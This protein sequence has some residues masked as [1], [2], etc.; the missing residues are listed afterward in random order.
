MSSCSCG[1]VVLEES[2]SI[3]AAYVVVAVA[4]EIG[5]SFYGIVAV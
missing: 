2:F 1:L 4:F 3:G 5:V